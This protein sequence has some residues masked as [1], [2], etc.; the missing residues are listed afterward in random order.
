[1]FK[2]QKGSAASVGALI[3]LV[4]IVA[5]LVGWIM[6]IAGI[7]H[8]IGGPITAMFIARCV[9]VLAFPLGAVLGYF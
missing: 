8:T 4:L 6:N 2:K 9:G 1:M 3:Y 5:A 7:V